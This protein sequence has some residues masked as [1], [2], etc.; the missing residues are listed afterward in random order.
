MKGS[1][2]EAADVAAALGTTTGIERDRCW[3]CKERGF[4]K[5]WREKQARVGG[6]AALPY[7]V[8]LPGAGGPVCDCLATDMLVGVICVISMQRRWDSERLPCPF[9]LCHK[10]TS[11][12][13]MFQREAALSPGVPG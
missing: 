4:L 2:A 12:Q 11:V 9:P 6:V 3:L 10:E 13:A 7:S 5:D 1:R 8:P